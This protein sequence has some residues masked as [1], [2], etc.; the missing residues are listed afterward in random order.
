MDA[1]TLAG[2]AGA[3][4]IRVLNESNDSDIAEPFGFVIPV[5]PLTPGASYT[6]TATFSSYGHERSASFTKTFTTDDRWLFEI[7][8]QHGPQSVKA[9]L[10]LAFKLKKSY[11]WRK[12]AKTGLPITVTAPATAK[13][14]ILAAVGRILAVKRPLTKTVKAGTTTL[15]LKLDPGAVAFL[16]KKGHGRAKLT[17]VAGAVAAKT[18]LTR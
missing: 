18:T 16:L 3:V 5:Q 1:A 7:K 17:V 9:A 12:I 2:P 14:Q 15:K 4:D 13:L 8:G 11:S 10:P 6:L